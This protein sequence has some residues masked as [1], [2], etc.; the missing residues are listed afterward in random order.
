VQRLPLGSR[1]DCKRSLLV[2]RRNAHEPKKIKMTTKRALLTICLSC[3][4]L[5]L[6]IDIFYFPSGLTFGD[7]R[8]FY[9][10]AFDL[11]RMGYFSVEG[12]RAWEMPGT[13]V[14]FSSA[15]AIA[16]PEHVIVVVRVAQAL[17]LVCEVLLVGSIARDAFNDRRAAVIA[18]GITAIYPFFL[19]Y[20]GLLLSETLFT[21]LLVAAFAALYRWR[22]A[23]LQIDAL[24][25]L[26]SVLFGV[27]SWVK[28]TLLFIPPVLIFGASYLWLRD[29]A[30]SIK[31]GATAAVIFA[32]VLAPWCIRNALVFGAF[33][34]LTTSSGSNLYLGNNAANVNFGIDWT[35]DVDKNTVA[36]INALPELERQKA[37]RDAAV[38]WILSNPSDF[39]RG[40]VKKF[41]RYWNVVPNATEFRGGL[42]PII[43]LLSFG[44]ILLLAIGCIL[45]LRRHVDLVPLYALIAIFTALH[46][47]VIASLRYR[48][49]IEP[50]L[51]VMAS[52]TLAAAW[53]RLTIH[54]VRSTNTFGPLAL[55]ELPR[56][57]LKSARKRKDIT[58]IA[59]RIG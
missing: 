7:E 56:P 52:G 38:D 42:F 13:A 19:Y 49:P 33:V 16:A 50:F 58:N 5:C 57:P 40:A 46:C 37:Y 41:F 28:P 8:R 51:I 14:F 27:A 12:A 17:L 10:S 32:T 36:R 6:V 22:A 34:P 48:L 11:A 23:G 24:L 29:A 43:S 54:K 47:V 30:R 2:G 18:A 55:A 3:I 26:T 45:F 15:F 4:L 9:A 31:I 25:V 20:Q 44:P 53:K 39:A 21:W 35:T 59:N 1:P